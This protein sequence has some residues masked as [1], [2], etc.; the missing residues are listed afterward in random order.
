M[1]EARYQTIRSLVGEL[2]TAARH[3][4]EVSGLTLSKDRNGATRA[5]RAAKVERPVSVQFTD[6]EGGTR[7]RA[8]RA[9][10]GPPALALER[11]SSVTIREDA[12]TVRL[13]NLMTD[14][15]VTTGSTAGATI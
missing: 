7:G 13:R 3:P 8:K 14:I 9:E 10:S 12:N 15:G 2:G 5:V 11:G 4:S 1:R 6:V